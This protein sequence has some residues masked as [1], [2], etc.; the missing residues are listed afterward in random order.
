MRSGQ[1]LVRRG[2][3]RGARP[4]FVPILA[5]TR[6]GWGQL[7]EREGGWGRRVPYGGA[8]RG[9]GGHP[10]VLRPATA[11]SPGP[12]TAIYGCL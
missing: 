1:R 11:R 12:D 7:E 5:G 6:G 10:G 8:G 9:A 3:H 2:A 4:S